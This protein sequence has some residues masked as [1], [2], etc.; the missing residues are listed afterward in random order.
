MKP[1]T[2]DIGMSFVGHWTCTVRNAM[3]NGVT[4]VALAAGRVQILLVGFMGIS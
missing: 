4:G 3:S 2:S 1:E